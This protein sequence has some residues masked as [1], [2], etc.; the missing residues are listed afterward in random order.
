MVGTLTN[1]SGTTGRHHLCKTTIHNTFSLII[2]HRVALNNRQL[3]EWVLSHGADPNARCTFERTPL[4]VAVGWASRDIIDLLL[5]HGGS[6]ESG[7]LLHCAVDWLKPGCA[8]IIQLL[9][10]KG[11]D[12]NAIKYQN[13]RGSY[14]FYSV[15]L[16]LGTSLHEAADSGRST[17]VKFL[18]ANGADPLVRDTNDY[19]PIDMAHRKGHTDVVDLLKPY[20]EA[21]P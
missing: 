11:C 5:Q 9:L 6:V 10:G 13:H 12:I 3:C 18:L 1:Q 16:S 7:Q 21:T 19:L 17:V 20:S 15:L 14:D 2:K 8:E 4:S